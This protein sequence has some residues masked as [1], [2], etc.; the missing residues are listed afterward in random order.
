MNNSRYSADSAVIRRVTN[1]GNGLNRQADGYGRKSPVK[2]KRRLL[3]KS[4][5]FLLSAILGFGTGVVIYMYQIVGSVQYVI[6]PFV[7]PE[8]YE[9]VDIENLDAINLEGNTQSAWIEGG[10]TR[11][12]VDPDFPIKKVRQKDKNVENILVFGI[13]S[14]GSHDIVCRADAIM[15]VSLD[16]RSKAIRITSLMR[17]CSVHIDGR[18]EPDKL[19]HAY[20]YGGVGL[21]INTINDNFGLDISRFVMLDFH[22]SSKIIDIV[23]GVEIN[24]KSG[25]VKYANITIKEHN[26]L[27]GTNVPYL[28]HEGNQLLSGPQAIGW[29]RIRY[30]DSDFVRTGRQRTIATSLMGKVS[31]MDSI[32]QLAILEDM[33]G[34]FE[35]NMKADDLMRVGITGVGIV[36]DIQQYRVPADGMFT[37]QPSPWKMILDW[38]KQIPELHGFIWGE[39]K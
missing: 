37:T 35:T 27:F 23:G 10:H 1:S 34:M 15:I 19:G 8:K 16:Q 5:V 13:D 12:Y 21:L 38:E 30:L 31:A 20:A 36:S 2:K 7:N 17:D 3:L 33:A 18:S 28:T 14:R 24:V 6:T 29:A 32:G 22:S 11:V 9:P 4:L 39:E 26:E 25:E